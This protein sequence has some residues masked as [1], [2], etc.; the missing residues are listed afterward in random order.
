MKSILF[1]LLTWVALIAPSLAQAQVKP[2]ISD[3]SDDYLLWSA[4]IQVDP[5]SIPCEIEYYRCKEAGQEFL[6][7][8]IV[9]AQECRDRIRALTGTPNTTVPILSPSCLGRGFIQ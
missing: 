4:L 9:R 8:C 6:A 7:C 1:V 2:L 3:P 5:D